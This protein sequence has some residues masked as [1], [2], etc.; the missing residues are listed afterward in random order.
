MG[1]GISR[2]V[3]GYWNAAGSEDTAAGEQYSSN[4][5]PSTQSQKSRGP[6]KE[7]ALSDSPSGKST[8]SGSAGRRRTN[9]PTVPAPGAPPSDS[10]LPYI[11]EK[12]GDGSKPDSYTYTCKCGHKFTTKGNINRHMRA[13][14]Y[15]AIHMKYVNP[16]NAVF[17]AFVSRPRVEKGSSSTPSKSAG[18]G[19]ASTPSTDVKTTGSNKV[20]RLKYGVTVQQFKVSQPVADGATDSPAKRKRKRPE[21]KAVTTAK[22]SKA[23]APLKK[24][25]R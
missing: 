12:S 9:N 13:Q 21:D 23:D 3:S 20:D 2:A 16:N 22:D 5:S 17:D 14:R 8:N 19:S 10:E 24:R 25:L 1:N 11:V 7:A 6:K 15:D 18:S 4:T